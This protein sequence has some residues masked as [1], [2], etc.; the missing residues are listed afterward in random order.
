[1]V[2]TALDQSFK[3][4]FAIA[5]GVNRV[6]DDRISAAQEED[7]LGDRKRRRVART[8]QAAVTEVAGM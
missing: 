8:P 2:E 4:G 1:M 7:E 6:E 5:V 3:Q